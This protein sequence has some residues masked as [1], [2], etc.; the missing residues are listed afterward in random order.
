MR[1]AEATDDWY[2]ADGVRLKPEYGVRY[3]TAVCSGVKRAMDRGG[4]VSLSNSLEKD[5]R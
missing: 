1:S 2:Q 3:V 5:M 4:V